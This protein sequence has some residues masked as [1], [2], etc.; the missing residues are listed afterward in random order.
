MELIADFSDLSE[1][2][3]LIYSDEQ[4]IMQVLLCLQT[5]AIKFTN[6]GSVNV[7]VSISDD[8]YL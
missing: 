3:S 6:E 1:R 2:R 8:R 7:H 4:R 5:N